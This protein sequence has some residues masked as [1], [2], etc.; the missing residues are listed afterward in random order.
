M[1]RSIDVSQLADAVMKELR[2]YQSLATQDVKKSVK[3]AV[4]QVRKEIRKNAPKDGGR[5]SK[6]FTITTEMES[7]TAIS[8]TV[9]SPKRYMLTHLLE[10]G[11]AKRGGGRVEGRPHIEPAR[12]FGEQFLTDELTKALQSH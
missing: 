2:D 3:N 10:N 12:E 9:H 4:K 1:P 11:H 5:Y 6:S 8:L 7:P